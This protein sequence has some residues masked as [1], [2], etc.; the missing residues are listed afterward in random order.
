MNN[1]VNIKDYLNEDIFTILNSFVSKMEN[2]LVRNIYVGTVVEHDEYDEENAAIAGKCKI[3]VY[4]VYDNIPVEHLPWALPDKSWMGSQTGSFI[5]P[6]VGT[7]VRVEFDSDN[8]YR[9]I[10][11]AKILQKDKV[12]P[13]IDKHYPNNMLMWS[14]DA[15]SSLQHDR[16]TGEE[17]KTNMIGEYKPETVDVGAIAN[18]DSSLVTVDAA[19]EYTDDGNYKI[20]AEFIS[21]DTLLEIIKNID[22]NL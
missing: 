21:I 17:I 6:P 16:T 1:K 12:S 22:L 9:P 10:Y 5:V 8:I 11:S 14:T 18:N 4:G 20:D 7:L 2:R 15:G 13:L 3:M 19:A